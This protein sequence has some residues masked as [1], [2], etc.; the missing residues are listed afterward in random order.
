MRFLKRP[1]VLTKHPTMVD[2]KTL[3]TNWCP[4]LPKDSQIIGLKFA[5]LQ[6][7]AVGHSIWSLKD[8]KNKIWPFLRN[9]TRIWCQGCASIGTM[10]QK[11]SE[12]TVLKPGSKFLESKE[13]KL[14]SSMRRPSASTTSANL[15]L[16]IMQSEKPPV[17]VLENCAPRWSRRV[18]QKKPKMRWEST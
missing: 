13:N 3:Q 16:T 12:D 9:T 1:W 7:C 17:I 4:W 11:E 2:L 10:L 18:N 14:W 5:M 6:V 15:K 8:V